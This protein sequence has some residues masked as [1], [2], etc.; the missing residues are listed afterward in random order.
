MKLTAEQQF[1]VTCSKARLN[2][3]DRAWLKQH[4]QAGLDW[5]EVLHQAV[6]HR[7]LNL[8][9]HHLRELEV[10]GSLERDLRNLMELHRL[11]IASR[12]RS[13]IGELRVIAREFEKVGVKAA[14]VKGGLLASTL[15]PSIETRYFNDLDFVVNIKDVTPIT[16]ALERVGYVQGQFDAKNHAIVAATRRQK[17]F[18]QTSSHE[19]QEFLK[20]S[21]HPLVPVIEVDINHSI[22]WVGN[23]PY[24]IS[25]E[26]LISRAV[27]ADMG[28]DPIYRLDME[29]ALL[30][31]SSHLFREATIL[32]WISEGRDLK[33]Y[34]FAD[35]YSYV[36]RFGPQIDWKK[37]VATVIEH[38]LQKVAYYPFHFVNELY[39]QTI[40]AEVMTALAPSD[41][42][43]LEEYAIEGSAPKRWKL[44]FA[45]RLFDQARKSEAFGAND[46]KPGAFDRMKEAL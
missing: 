41:L 37:F 28:D 35:I 11:A 27:K 15:Y 4:T 39:G 19:L 17:I 22:L 14:L 38:N 34:K 23:C 21:D 45:E 42:G 16:A 44:G 43:F 3:A 7:T 29:D 8:I 24:S 36:D 1:I 30:Q 2:D 10:F 9:T 32:H 31:L 25:T 46:A 18:H 5:R 26:Q 12:N 6:A 13:Y 40:P 20:L 33:I